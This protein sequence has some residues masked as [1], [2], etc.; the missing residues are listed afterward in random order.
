MPPLTDRQRKIQGLQ[1]LVDKYPD[2][3]GGELQHTMP[4][5]GGG[6]STWDTIKRTKRNVID[7]PLENLRIRQKTQALKAKKY[8]D[9]MNSILSE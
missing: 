7:S 8:R 2:V 3:G 1:A 5:E 4:G 6:E 9:E